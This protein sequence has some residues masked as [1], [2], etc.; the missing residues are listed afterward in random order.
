MMALRPFPCQLLLLLLLVLA[1]PSALLLCHSRQF[2]PANFGAFPN[3]G[4]DDTASL[5]AAINAAIA[6][7]PF[8]TV[9][10]E[11]GAYELT[12][13]LRVAQAVSFSLL[14]A[15]A[16]G[17]SLLLFLNNSGVV[18]YT[19]CSNLTLADFTVDFVP[20]AWPFTAGTVVGASQSPPFTFDVLPVAPHIAQAGL[21]ASAVFVYDPVK[22]RPAFGPST[23]ELFQSVSTPSVLLGNGTVR[24]SLA[25]QSPFQVGQSVVVRYDG[26]EHAISGDDSAQVLLR[27]L[28]LFTA[29]DMSHANLRVHNLSVVDYHVK[30]G[31][32][33]WLSSWADCMH[34][35]DNRG[36]ISIVN[37]SCEGMGDDGLNVHA[38]YFNCTQ[39]VNSSTAVISLTHSTWLDTLAV[40]VGTHMA[41]ARAESPFVAYQRLRVAALQPNSDSSFLFTFESS[42][43]RVQ[44]GDVVYVADAPSLLLSNFTVASNRARGVL[45]ETRDVSIDRCLFRYTSGPALLFQPSFYWEEAEPGSHVRVTETV[46]EGCNQGIAQQ[47]GVVAILPDPVQL[48]GVVDRVTVERS[49]F[50][51]GEYSRSLLQ[52]FNGRR[53]TLSDNFVSDFDPASVPVHV[54]NSN[55][56]LLRNNNVWN[57]SAAGYVMERAA[58]CNDSLSSGI[59]FTRDAVN[60]S[61]SATVMPDPSGYGVRVVHHSQQRVLPWLS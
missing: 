13:T 56:L 10:L 43:S 34:F 17:R 41:F 7:G 46:F 19:R 11:S 60:A 1:S 8:A 31:P 53:V 48:L 3:D 33:R 45:L 37:S 23:L 9:Q 15:P 39:I 4:L 2:D 55:G 61:I 28:T 21:L 12:T 51:Q 38:Y 52:C 27:G 44:V 5:Q 40:G 6:S 24:F 22:Q 14:G 50:L 42:L 30:K 59:H 47:Q 32:G 29:W 18:Y 26:G 25:Y 35:G 16:P 36:S 49:S 57:S 58:P 54:C 20:A